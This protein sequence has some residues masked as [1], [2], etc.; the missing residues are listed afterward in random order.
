M[1]FIAIAIKICR[2]ERRICTPPTHLSEYCIFLAGPR[3]VQKKVVPYWNDLFLI[4]AS[5]YC[6]LAACHASLYLLYL[7][8]MPSSSRRRKQRAF[9][10]SS[11]STLLG[12]ISS[13]F[14]KAGIALR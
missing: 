12:W 7:S 11:V 13:A 9:S 4:E 1:K 5:D 10:D 3:R 2:F 8:I 14:S 6:A